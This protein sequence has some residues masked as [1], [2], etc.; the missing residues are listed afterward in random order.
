MRYK[1]FL[2]SALL[3]E[4]DEVF[5][6]KIIG[7]PDLVSYEG[8]SVKELKQAFH[9]AVDD[10][11]DICTRYN[12]PVQ[13]S[14]TGTFNVRIN[15]ELHQLVSLTAA[16]RGVSLNKVVQEAIQNYVAEEAAPYKSKHKKK[17]G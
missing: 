7:I 15:P 17:T 14:L 5:T 2:G 8:R 3:S 13:K 9:E 10:Y 12:K 4:A 1:G 16:E 6:G 11:I